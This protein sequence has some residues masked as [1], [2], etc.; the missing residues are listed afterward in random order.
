MFHTMNFSPFCSGNGQE[1][2]YVEGRIWGQSA[3]V[4]VFIRETGEV[5]PPDSM[6]KSLRK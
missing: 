2:V 1:A 6:I 4:R 3:C 5:K